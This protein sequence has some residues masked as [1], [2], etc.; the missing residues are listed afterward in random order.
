[1]SFSSLLAT[2]SRRAAE[3][4]A[5]ARGVDL[6]I[7]QALDA[8]ETETRMSVAD[9]WEYER[10]WTT[11]AETQARIDLGRH[12]G[13]NVPV[14]TGHIVRRGQVSA[15]SAGTGSDRRGVHHLYV[16]EAFERGRIRREAG[17]ALCGARGSFD[18][19]LDEITC[20]PRITVFA[21]AGAC[22]RCAA[23]ILGA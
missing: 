18:H 17:Q 5:A 22:S 2:I 10:A 11:V 4:S 13:L 7:A 9:S 14:T 15:R 16:C 20:S 3:A 19:T 21:G 23:L 1:M 12:L 8:W 6:S